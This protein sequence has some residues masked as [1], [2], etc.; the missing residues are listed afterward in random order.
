MGPPRK[1]SSAKLNSQPPSCPLGLGW[2]SHLDLSIKRVT[3]SLSRL[4]KDVSSPPESH[5]VE[6][7]VN[8]SRPWMWWRRPGVWGCKL[9][10]TVSMA[11]QCEA[12][13]ESCHFYDPHPGVQKDQRGSHGGQRLLPNHLLRR[14]RVQGWRLDQQPHGLY[15]TFSRKKWTCVSSLPPTWAC[16]RPIM[17]AS[18]AGGSESTLRQ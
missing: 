12:H 14:K 11:R 15:A 16:A 6:T 17:P 1:V 5:P 13:T 18:W 3:E 4:P 8:T 10:K 9:L 7:A 2:F